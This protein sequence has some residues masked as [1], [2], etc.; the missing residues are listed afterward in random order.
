MPVI[1]LPELT[2]RNQLFFGVNKNLSSDKITGGNLRGN[3]L[4]VYD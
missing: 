3:I 1:F 4:E 2:S